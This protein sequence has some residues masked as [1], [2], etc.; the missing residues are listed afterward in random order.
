VLLFVD[1]ECFDCAEKEAVLAERI[2]AENQIAAAAV[3]DGALGLIATL[4]NR[5]SLALEV[6]D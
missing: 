4:I 3:P 2:C 5:G 6:E 1:G